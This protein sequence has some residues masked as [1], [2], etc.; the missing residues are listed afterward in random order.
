MP[1]KSS[2]SSC[3]CRSADSLGCAAIGAQVVDI[4]LAQVIADSTVQGCDS[5]TPALASVQVMQTE[6]SDA[7]GRIGYVIPS[8]EDIERRA[9]RRPFFSNL[10]SWKLWCSLSMLLRASG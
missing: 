8:D 7:N 3:P 9:V 5:C 6:H 4:M 10:A 1:V 2:F